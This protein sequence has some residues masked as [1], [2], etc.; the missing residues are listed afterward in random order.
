[1]NFSI[2]LRQFLTLQSKTRPFSD[3]KMMQTAIIKTFDTS[4]ISICIDAVLRIFQYFYK[5]I[6]SGLKIGKI[7]L[8]RWFKHASFHFF[9]Y[10]L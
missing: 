4:S 1:M 2:F 7:E 10:G 5:C 6:F 8:I 3:S 9:S